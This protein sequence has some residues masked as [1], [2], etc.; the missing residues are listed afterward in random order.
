MLNNHA[1]AALKDPTTSTSKPHMLLLP[2]LT[3]PSTIM[4]MRIKAVTIM[5]ILEG[6]FHRSILIL[7]ANKE[8]GMG[9]TREHG[10]LAVHNTQMAGNM[11]AGASK[12]A[13]GS[14]HNS[15]IPDQ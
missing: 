1:M 9:I 6:N 11:E 3:P 15:S 5:M 7:I 10:K 12:E 2:S 13:E 14:L 8:E 4:P